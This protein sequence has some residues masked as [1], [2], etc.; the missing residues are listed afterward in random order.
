MVHVDKVS[1]REMQGGLAPG[2]QLFSEFL[3]DELWSVKQF[4]LSER[5]LGLQFPDPVV[6][7]RF[8][9]FLRK[10]QVPAQIQSI[11]TLGTFVQVTFNLV[12]ASYESTVFK[13]RSTFIH[14]EHIAP[15]LFRDLREAVEVLHLQVN[16]GL[17]K[18]S[19]SMFVL[20]LQLQLRVAGHR[21][22]M[23][24]VYGRKTR[25]AIAKHGGFTHS[26]LDFLLEA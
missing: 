24:G 22:P 17:T 6:Q 12:G 25:R 20:L 21:V 4:Q 1:V 8:L 3:K 26:T 13:V 15:A 18:K 16:L 11:E 14:P 7:E 19:R 2:V 9:G 5:S 10:V 23:D